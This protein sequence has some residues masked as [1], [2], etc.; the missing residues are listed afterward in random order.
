MQEAIGI[1]SSR[2]NLD[3]D[4]LREDSVRSSTTVH[5]AHGALFRQATVHHESSESLTDKR[6]PRHLFWRREIQCRAR[7]LRGRLNSRQQAST[8]FDIVWN[9]L[10]QP[11]SSFC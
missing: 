7:R 9:F 4:L 8:Q 6:V 11:D 5:G 2:D 10:F 3:R 1:E